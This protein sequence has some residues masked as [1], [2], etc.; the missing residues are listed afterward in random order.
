MG[1]N[2][3]VLN[4]THT[5]ELEHVRQFFRN[6]AAWLGVDLCYQ[7]FDAEMASLPGAY[8]APDGRLL[9][10]EVAGKPAG[11]VGIRKFSDGV[12]EMKRL[13]V[14]PSMRGQGVGR[15]LALAAL[16]RR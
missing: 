16:A 12:C 7:N 9:F 11:C 10:A 13:Y 2:L 4:A 5:A 1:I 15:D 14:E 8:S 6:Y 3:R